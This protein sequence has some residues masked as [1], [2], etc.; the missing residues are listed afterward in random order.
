MSN[1]FKILMNS[2]FGVM[3]TRVERFKNF[4]IVT[5]KEQVDKQVKKT[6]YSRR[7]IVN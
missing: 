2:L 5:T 1:T 7:N 4:K 6:N 3:M